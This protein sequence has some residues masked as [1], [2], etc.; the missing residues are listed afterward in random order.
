VVFVGAGTHEMKCRAT[1]R[2]PTIQVDEVCQ[3]SVDER[4]V[5]QEGALRRRPAEQGAD[6]VDTGEELGVEAA[7]M[8]TACGS[9]L[10]CIP[11]LVPHAQRFA[12]GH[13]GF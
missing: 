4:N 13:G 6:G 3:E 10:S 2:A 1:L 5:Q 9:M 8:H 12:L 7:C 11:P